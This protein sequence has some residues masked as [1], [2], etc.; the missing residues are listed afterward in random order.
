MLRS[1]FLHLKAISILQYLNTILLGNNFCILNFYFH[2]IL[3]I[4]EAIGD[5]LCS[6]TYNLI[7]TLLLTD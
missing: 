1:Q 3:E 2:L 5:T 4:L 6:Y 7:R